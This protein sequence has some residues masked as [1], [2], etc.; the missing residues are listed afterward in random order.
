MKTP[1][2]TTR[3]QREF[4]RMLARGKDEAKFK[5]VAAKLLLG[6]NLAPRYEDHP[7]QGTF[8]GWRDCH[9]EPDWVLVYKRTPT[10]V[11]FG[12]TGTHSDLF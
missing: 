8:V 10:E 12:R 7:L 1:V 3:F 6:E 5:A 9:I 11:I 2:Y 4:V